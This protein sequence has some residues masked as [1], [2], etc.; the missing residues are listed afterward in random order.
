MRFKKPL[1]ST[2]LFAAIFLIGILVLYI[3]VS[4]ALE[5]DINAINNR[6]AL[7]VSKT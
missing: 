2:L 6:T 7:R 4:K 5:T 3:L 1:A